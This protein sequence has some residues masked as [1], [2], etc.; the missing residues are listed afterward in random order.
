MELP[1]LTGGAGNVLGDVAVERLLLIELPVTY[2]EQVEECTL[3]I[4]GGQARQQQRVAEREVTL[5]EELLGIHLE[6]Q[7][8]QSL[9]HVAQCLAGFLGDVLSSRSRSDQ[10][11][12]TLRLLGGV[13]IR[14]LE[15]LDELQVHRVRVGEAVVDDCRNEF[16]TCGFRGTEPTFAGYDLILKFDAVV[17]RAIAVR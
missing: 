17:E 13:E 5:R 16:E 7:Q 2:A 12:V 14:A 1:V 9:L 11:A 10:G 3:L 15:V 4:F 6:R 8:L